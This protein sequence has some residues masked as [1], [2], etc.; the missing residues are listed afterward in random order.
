M[1]SYTVIHP[2]F[3]PMGAG[4]VCG[5]GDCS[6]TGADGAVPLVVIDAVL[7]LLSRYIQGQGSVVFG[8]FGRWGSDVPR[9]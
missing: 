8:V 6:F 2:S 7:R 4:G 9:G 5:L 1:Y 3:P